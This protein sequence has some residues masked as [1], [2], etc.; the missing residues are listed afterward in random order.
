MASRSLGIRQL[1]QADK[2][3]SEKVSEAHEHKKPRLKQAKQAQDE[4]EQYHLQRMKFKA[5]GA[6][7]LW[8]HSSCSTEVEEEPQETTT[9]QTNFWQNRDAI[10]DNVLA[11]ACDIWPD[12]HREYHI[13]EQGKKQEV[14]SPWVG[15][16]DA[17]VEEE[18]LAKLELQ[19]SEKALHEFCLI[20]SRSLCFLENS[21]SSFFVQTYSLSKNFIFL[22]CIS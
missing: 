18:A 9:L 12:I 7:A 6:V 4:T 15:I 13:N 1:L 14:P 22:P 10:L 19:S 11:F 3:A 17:F 21:K 16:L 2:R 20:R 5:K 8:L